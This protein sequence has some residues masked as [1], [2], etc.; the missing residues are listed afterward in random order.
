MITIVSGLPR[1]GT[2]M[3]M[4][5]LVAAGFTPFT[6]YM[7]KADADNERGYLE[8]E[9]AKKLKTD[10]SWLAQAEKHVIKIL[11][12]LL[13]YL[14]PEHEYSILFMKRDL[15]AVFAS[16]QRMLERS[17]HGPGQVQFDDFRGSMDN[18]VEQTLTWCRLRPNIR[19][20]ECNYERLIQ[21]PGEET[22]KVQEFLGSRA[23]PMLEVIDP[24][25]RH[26]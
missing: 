5:M 7:R 26:H 9:F 25:M 18:L 12:F 17:G 3:M 11:A 1:S 4:Q 10:N 15:S 13:R 24:S 16:Q 21:N 2:S 22:A 20:L 8:H 19:L 23:Q 14:P 6:D